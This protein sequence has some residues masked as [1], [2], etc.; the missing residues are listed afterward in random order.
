ML[1]WLT[2]QLSFVSSAADELFETD[3]VFQIDLWLCWSTLSQK[4]WPKSKR[5]LMIHSSVAVLT[6]S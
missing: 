4:D 3:F 2:C 1:I 5:M 6:L